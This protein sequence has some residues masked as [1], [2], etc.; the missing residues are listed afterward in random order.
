MS[1]IP[2]RGDAVQSEQVL[3]L[4]CSAGFFSFL[5][6]LVCAFPEEDRLQRKRSKDET[7]GKVAW[8]V[9]V[10]HCLMIFIKGF[11]NIYY[12]L[13]GNMVKFCPSGRNCFDIHFCSQYHI[14][15][16]NRHT[17]VPCINGLV[18]GITTFVL[19]SNSRHRV[20]FIL[21]LRISVCAE[22]PN[23]LGLR[24][25]QKQKVWSVKKKWLMSY[26][27]CDCLSFPYRLDC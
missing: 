2:L 13:L 1:E 14:A 9:L 4:L 11:S 3:G 5:P 25:H 26:I 6:S 8:Y 18:N 21:L 17:H 15:L 20:P 7:W 24:I 19:L 16:V 12:Y 22:V 10:L 27:L 23:E